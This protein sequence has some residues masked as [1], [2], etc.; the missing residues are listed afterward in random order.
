MSGSDRAA[1]R[2]SSSRG[3]SRCSRRR[4]AW[5]RAAR[6][7]SAPHPREPW[8]WWLVIYPLLGALMAAV[9]NAASNGLNQIYDL[10]IDRGEQAEAPAA[11][12]GRMSMREAWAFTWVTFA[13]AWALAWLVAPGGRHECFW[14]VVAA[15]LITTLY[16]VPPFRTK[17]LGIW[18]N[19][20]V[21]IPRGVLLKVA[22]WSSVKTGGR[23]RAVVHRRRSS[24]CSCWARRRRRTSPTWK[25]TRAAA[26]ERCRSS[27]A[28]GAR[29]G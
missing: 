28:S 7:P 3:R 29:P 23:L 26:A 24:G 11:T 12:S 10:D 9:L 5:R 6:R 1:A 17:R 20:T 22:G 16:S 19:V 2:T 25:A 8:S 21:A 15:T 14:L 13:L 18:A 4:S 27:T